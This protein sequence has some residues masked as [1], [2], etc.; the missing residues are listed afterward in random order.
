MSPVP[1]PVPCRPVLWQC[2]ERHWRRPA[3]LRRLR[4]TAS[5]SGL[6]AVTFSLIVDDIVHPDGRTTMAALGGGG[7]QARAVPFSA[8]EAFPTHFPSPRRRRSGCACTR[9]VF[10]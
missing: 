7:A 6:D 1:V 4:R 10:Q 9:P 2:A 8:N 3:S 5:T